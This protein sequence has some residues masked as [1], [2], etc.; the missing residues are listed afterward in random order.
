[1]KK[2]N[3]QPLH[4]P[5]NNAEPIEMGHQKGVAETGRE[6]CVKLITVLTLES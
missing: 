4:N 2:I 5:E 6:E 1:M 3:D